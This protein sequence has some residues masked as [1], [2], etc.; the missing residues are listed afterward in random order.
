MEVIR[1]KKYKIIAFALFCLV[2]TSLIRPDVV[3]AAGE[4]DMNREATL[5]I[6]VNYDETG[7]PGVKYELYLV[8]VLDENGNLTPVEAFEKYVS[9]LDIQNRED[10]RWQAAAEALEREIVLGNLGGIQLCD[11][12][13]TD[14]SGMVCFPS[15]GKH[16]SLGLY[17]VMGTRMAR[18][19]RVY[20]TSPFFVLLPEQNQ[21]TDTW[22]Y[23]VS[24]NAKV[25][26]GSAL[27]DFEVVKIWE[28]DCHE[29]ERPQRITIQLMQDGSAYGDAVTLPWNGSWKYTWHDLEANHKWTVVEKQEEGY[30]E[31][32]IRQEGNT[33]VVTNTCSKPVDPAQPGK[34]SLPQTGQLWWPVPVLLS[35]GVLSVVFGL[36]R[37][38]GARNEE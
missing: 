25:G 9:G 38:R 26:E 35:A 16:L 20:S 24:V 29:D 6:T 5:V 4:I 15:D 30:Q 1:M 18:G 14:E 23:S 37:Q 8:S 32:D 11:S 2:A 22:E 36:I 17:L 3:A 7:L 31:P 10:E 21:I 27:A 13:I 28:D 19:E 34:P 12:A 33:F